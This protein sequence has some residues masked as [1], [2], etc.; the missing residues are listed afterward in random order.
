MVMKIVCLDCGEEFLEDN[1][2]TLKI[3]FEA[4]KK[5]HAKRNQEMKRK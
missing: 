4:H 3:K 2:K 1:V 5:E